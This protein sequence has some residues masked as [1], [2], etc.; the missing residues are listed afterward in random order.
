MIFV[1]GTP[2]HS[3]SSSSEGREILTA[4]LEHPILVSASESFKTI[5]EKKISLAGEF[6]L[7]KDSQTKH[8]YVFQREYATVDPAFVEVIGTDEATT[9]VGLVIRNPRN[10]MTSVAHIDSPRVVDLG[11]TQILPLII[12][13]NP[14]AQLD[15]QDN[16]IM[17][18]SQSQAEIKGY[19]FPLCSKIIEALQRRQESF[20]LQTLCVLGHN[21]ERDSD[22][23]AY[24]AF[25]GLLV[26]TLT[27]LVMPASFDRGS[28]CPDEIVRRIR[29]TVS[30]GDPRWKG[31]LLETYDTHRDRFQIAACSWNP[32]WKHHALS[33]QQLSDS[34]ILLGCS[35]SP[36]AEGPEFVDNERRLF[37]YLVQHPDWRDTFPMRKSRVFKRRDDG[38]WITG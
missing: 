23:N 37:N 34:E 6:G 30:S 7:E 25:N 16:D 27:G 31:K 15:L 13:Q 5:P 18:G 2:F 22:G 26:E 12:D 10:G 38:S 3:S 28:R 29:V 19:S 8:I 11:L 32:G 36:L 4:L 17:V 20:H 35:T 9:C 33:L 21:T 14:D 24:P 1:D